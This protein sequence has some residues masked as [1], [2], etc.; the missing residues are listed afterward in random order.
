MEI[1]KLDQND[2]SDF[3]QV[4]RIF[5]DVFEND[6]DLPPDGHLKKML[7]NPD[8][9]VFVVRLHHQV[10]GGLTVHVLQSCYS[11]KPS[12]Y[13]Y[14]VGIDREFQGKGFGKSLI[15]EVCRFCR[16]NGFKEAYVEAESDDTDAVAFY[17]KTKFTTEMEATHYTYS[18]SE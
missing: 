14:D 13:I 17:R 7:S 18:F 10:I 11:E 6:G 16:Q 12:A 2:L 9:M 3:K 15:E 4:I 8:F 5:N 1:K